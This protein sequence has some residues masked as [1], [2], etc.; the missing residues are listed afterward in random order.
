MTKLT[1][2]PGA[3]VDDRVIAALVTAAADDGIR[4]GDVIAVVVEEEADDDQ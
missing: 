3:E 2:P 4:P 1:I